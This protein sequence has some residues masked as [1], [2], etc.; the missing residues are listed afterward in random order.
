MNHHKFI[1]SL[2]FDKEF[3]AVWRHDS[4]LPFLKSRMQRMRLHRDGRVTL[5]DHADDADPREEKVDRIGA[6]FHPLTMDLEILLRFRQHPD[7][8]YSA[9]VIPENAQ[10]QR[11]YVE[12]VRRR[13]DKKRRRDALEMFKRRR[14][15]QLQKKRKRPCCD[16]FKCAICLESGTSELCAFDCG[17]VFHSACVERCEACPKC[18]RRVNKRIKLYM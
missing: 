12:T 17:H 2:L 8:D 10:V 5:H 9:I 14:E 15:S 3:W 7:K 18:K 11:K 1:E 13:M 6:R 16:D 4:I